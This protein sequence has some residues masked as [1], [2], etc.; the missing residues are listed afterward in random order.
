MPSAARELPLD[1]LSDP[2]LYTK[3]E[4]IDLR[5]TI[6]MYARFL[7]PGRERNQQ[8]QIGQSLRRLF[9]NRKWMAANTIED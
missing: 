5:R 7:P 4:L 3:T 1:E 9:K 8:R 2:P 6:L